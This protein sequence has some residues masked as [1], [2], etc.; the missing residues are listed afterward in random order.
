ME[1][2]SIPSAIPP[3]AVHI[4]VVARPA[5]VIPAEAVAV[6][7]RAVVVV[8]VVAAEAAARTAEAEAAVVVAAAAI[9]ET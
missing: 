9:I 7:T 8:V 5:E 4:R 3:G 6:L 1:A 2:H